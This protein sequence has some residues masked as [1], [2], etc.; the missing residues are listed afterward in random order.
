M[1]TTQSFQNMAGMAALAA[2]LLGLLYSIAFVV[3]QNAMLSALCLLTGGLLSVVALVA[4]F[5]RLG[6]VDTQAAMLG[7]IFGTVAA[8]GSAIH[9][10]YDLAN[11]LHPLG[12]LPEGVANLPN[13]IDPRGLLTFGVAGLAVLIAGLLM[14]RHPLFSGGFTALTFVLAV[15][16]I[17]VYLGRLIVLTASN[18]LILIPAA[19][20]GFIVN[21]LWYVMV[22]LNLRRNRLADG[23]MAPG[24]VRTVA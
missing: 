7:L 1:K 5:E 21:P 24:E 23:S 6:E 4:L 9:G 11:A 8:L 16:L 17:I 15:L 20:T 3:M 12:T 18:P 19:L 13:P 10:G 2:A 22:G 14:R